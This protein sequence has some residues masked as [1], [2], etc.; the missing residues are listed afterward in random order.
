[1]AA[2]ANDELVRLILQVQ[3]EEGVDDLREK[4]AYTEASLDQ[5]RRAYERGDVGLDEFLKTGQRLS[6]EL[7]RQRGIM[8]Q[9]EEAMRAQALAADAATDEGKFL[10][11]C[12]EELSQ[13][14]DRAAAAARRQGAA[15]GEAGKQSA[16]GARAV[17]ELSRGVED[18]TTGGP[19]GLL[20]NIPG[21]FE[22][23]GSAVGLSAGAVA[24][25]TGGVSILATAAYILWRN[26]DGVMG[27]LGQGKIETEAEE[28]ERL[29]KATKRT[30]DETKR[31]KEL[32]DEEKRQKE[33]EQEIE[34]LNKLK[35]EQ[36]R[37]VGAG[38]DKA[39]GESGGGKKVLDALTKVGVNE[40]IRNGAVNKFDMVEVEKATKAVRE[41][42]EQ[43]L[44]AA[45]KGSKKDRDFLRQTA[46]SD[47]TGVA[48]GFGLQ[49]GYNS[50]ETKAA[51]EEKVKQRKRTSEQQDFEKKMYEGVLKDRK[52]R[53]EAADKEA[54]ALQNKQDGEQ[55]RK[56]D[57]QDR[58][59]KAQ[60][61]RDAKGT[62][63]AAN[64]R[65]KREQADRKDPIGAK[66]RDNRFPLARQIQRQTGASDQAAMVAAEK[67]LTLS[68]RQGVDLQQA[69]LG[70][71]TQMVQQ[72]QAE[73]Q[74]IAAMQQQ[75]GQLQGQMR[76]Q[77]PSNRGNFNAFH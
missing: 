70:V 23:V 68:L 77:L 62:Q 24:G 22:S 42:F 17:L 54:V 49:L 7:H 18:F 66:I 64:D 71:M 72:A 14:S 47:D 5:L 1:M 57:K 37:E 16:A 2:G 63:K 55:K 60:K 50:P 8:G 39:I 45:S 46:L 6:A 25:L 53:Q 41:G 74:R 28:M 27:A 3:G 44:L 69:T 11:A 38:V 56:D 21:I 10:A 33:H 59:A 9:V 75:L 13:K 61:A 29:E 20:N 35:S 40:M 48:T 73:R 51:N 30:A 34:R 76:Q 19:I 4:F 31:L 36:E 32:K 12:M 15:T 26:W 65:L 43:N 67:A 52:E 58:E